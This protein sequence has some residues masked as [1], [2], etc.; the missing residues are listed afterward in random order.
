MEN[1][2]R[3]GLNGGVFVA[4]DLRLENWLGCEWVGILKRR[5]TEMNEKLSTF[6]IAMLAGRL[7][8]VNCGEGCWVSEWVDWGRR[9]EMKI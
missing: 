3:K 9:N 1:V 6:G 2:R 7:L 4:V 8:A 5:H